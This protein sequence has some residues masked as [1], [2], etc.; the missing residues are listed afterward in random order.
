MIKQ[1]IG[2]FSHTEHNNEQTLSNVSDNV[3]NNVD[4][5][6]RNISFEVVDI[7]DSEYPQYI[8]DNKEK[9]S[10]LIK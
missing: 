6:G 3:K 5:F 9:Y 1:K 10:H 4:L 7:D 2:S 8:M